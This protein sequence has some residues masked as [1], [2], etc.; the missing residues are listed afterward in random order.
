[1]AVAVFFAPM[2]KRP[3]CS[4]YFLLKKVLSTVL[5]LEKDTLSVQGGQVELHSVPKQSVLAVSSV[6]G[7]SSHH[8]YNMQSHLIF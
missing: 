7:E 1:M 8:P 5:S 6:L 4:L 2:M 3:K